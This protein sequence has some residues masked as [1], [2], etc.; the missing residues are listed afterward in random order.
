MI[1]IIANIPSRKLGKNVYAAR[2]ATYQ[3]DDDG[4]WFYN[5]QGTLEKV[6]QDDVIDSCLRA[7]NWPQIKSEHFPMYGFHN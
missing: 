6:R 7:T 4:Q 1:T 5:N 2:T 3:Q